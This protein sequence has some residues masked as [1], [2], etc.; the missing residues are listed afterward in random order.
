MK[1]TDIQIGV[2]YAATAPLAWGRE[3]IVTPRRVRFT[4]TKTGRWVVR[5]TAHG[6]IGPMGRLQWITDSAEV[7][8]LSKVQDQPSTRPGQVVEGATTVYIST[9]DVGLLPAERWD[10]NEWRPTV[11]APA[12]VHRT[13][14]ELEGAEAETVERRA[15]REAEA[16]IPEI[17]A[18]LHRLGLTNQVE[19]GAWGA[20]I[21]LTMYGPGA[22]VEAALAALNRQEAS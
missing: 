18:Q 8:D 14:A 9:P 5:Y 15:Q 21:K 19:V 6:G 11:V 7:I 2:E 16:R 12:D 3:P 13:W 17:R 4:S 22:A 20:G 1:K 10:G